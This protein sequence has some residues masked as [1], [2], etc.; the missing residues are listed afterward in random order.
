MLASIVSAKKNAGVGDKFEVSNL[1]IST[2]TV[3]TNLNA[4]VNLGYLTR[5]VN[6]YDQNAPELDLKSGGIYNLEFYGN[7]AREY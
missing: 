2:C 5:F 1:T 3:I 6:I 4:K 7:C